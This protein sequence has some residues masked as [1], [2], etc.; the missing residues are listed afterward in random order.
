MGLFIFNS[1]VLNHGILLHLVHNTRP[2]LDDQA[3]KS[4]QGLL[5]PRWHGSLN[6]GAMWLALKASVSKRTQAGAVQVKM[7][8]VR[9]VELKGNYSV[10]R[11]YHCFFDWAGVVW[12]KYGI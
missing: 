9:G 1:P 5:V 8:G 12:S 7:F 11:N 10:N 6:R 4:F 3:A 2:L